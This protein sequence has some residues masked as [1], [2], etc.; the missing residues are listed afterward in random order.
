MAPEVCPNCGATVPSK[1]RA[2][3]E[4]GSDADTGWSEAAESSGLNL[5]D[6]EFDYNEFVKE[7][8]GDAAAKPRGIAWGWWLVG[9]VVLAMLLLLAFFR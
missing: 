1:A 5:P 4:C 2:C 3:P 8:F 7:E 6:T 9:I